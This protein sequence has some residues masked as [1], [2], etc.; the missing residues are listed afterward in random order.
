[1]WS[2][3]E[4]SFKRKSSVYLNFKIVKTIELK[5]IYDEQDREKWSKEWTKIQGSVKQINI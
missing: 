5:I 1:M 3:T 2:I 4:E